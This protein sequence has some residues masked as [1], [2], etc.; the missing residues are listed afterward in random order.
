M[1]GVGFFRASVSPD[2]VI[3]TASVGERI[4]NFF[5]TGKSSVVSDKR[6]DAVLGMHD[7]RHLYC[8]IS[9]WTYHN[10]CLCGA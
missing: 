3:V 9:E 8:S 2:D 10:F 4:R 5:W 7:V 6:S 1:Y